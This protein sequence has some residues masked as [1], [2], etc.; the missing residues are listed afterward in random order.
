[1]AAAVGP[2][3]PSPLSAG[4]TAEAAGAAR[5]ASAPNVLLI[6]TDDERLGDQAYMPRTNRLI[7][8]Q[9]TTFTGI[10]PNPLCCPARASI[11]T[12]QFSQ[13]NGVR[14]NAGTFGGY[15]RFDPTDTLAT[16]LSDAGYTTAFMGKYLN[17]YTARGA[18]V[19]EPGWDF[20]EPTVAGVY[21][22]LNFAVLHHGRRVALTDTYQTDYFSDLGVRTL[23][24]L[25]R[26]PEPFFMW[27]SYMAPHDTCDAAS[28]P[29]CWGMPVSAERHR[30]LFQN[31]PLDAATEPSF[32]EADMSDKPPELASHPRYSGARI[33][34]LTMKNQARLR[35]LQAVDAGVARMIAALAR[36]GELANT[37]V[38]FTS[39]NGISMGQHRL[40]NK[41]YGYEEP[42]RVP[43]VMRGPGVP[44]G[45]TTRA[46][47][48]SADIAPTIA[49]LAGVT[50]TLTVDGRDLTAVAQ[51]APSWSTLLIRD[52]PLKFSDGPEEWLYRGVRTARYTYLEYQTST[53]RELYDRRRDAYEV[54]SVIDDPRYAAVLQEL[55][56]RLDVLENCAGASCR[57]DFGPLPRPF[58]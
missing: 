5:L 15:D 12:G 24:R 27:Q 10:S 49:A 52:G 13:N 26:A 2:A 53:T 37:L 11:L 58:P 50:P 3:S 18:A 23:N 56:T 28:E 21:Q 8:Q 22:Y 41:M 48:T 46:V 47:A 43:F 25:T 36:S 34:R 30:R 14:S 31:T 44:G 19:P 40:V 42:L 39:D 16:W 38:I 17:G 9:G 1:L 57:T 51:G 29:F 55:V 33:K 35:T 54:S 32:N 20:W 6:T 45:K 4:P 7:A